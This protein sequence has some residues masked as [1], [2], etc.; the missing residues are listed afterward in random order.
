MLRKL[1]AKG[2]VAHRVEGRTFIYRPLLEPQREKS[3]AFDYVLSRFFGGSV[4]QLMRHLVDCDRLT[5]QELDEVRRQIARS[6]KKKTT[7]GTK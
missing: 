2:Y 7:R 1:E 3:R 4:A 6:R 5:E